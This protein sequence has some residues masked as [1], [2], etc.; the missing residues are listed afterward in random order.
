M[1]S[2]ALL[3]G[4]VNDPELM[5]D[6][7]KRYTHKE[8]LDHCAHYWT[9]T[10]WPPERGLDW[11]AANGHN[12]IWRPPNRKYYMSNKRGRDMRRPFFCEY[13]FNRKSI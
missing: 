10:V 8:F 11:F 7:N 9:K 12:V 13:S 1:R 6:V 3:P 5:L 4:L 2:I